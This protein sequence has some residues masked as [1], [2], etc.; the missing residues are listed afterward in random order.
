MKPKTQVEAENKE[1]EVI[2]LGKELREFIEGSAAGV[3]E[4]VEVRKLLESIKHLIRTLE[5]VGLI[6]IKRGD[7][8]R[9]RYY[10]L[11]EE[12]RLRELELQKQRANMPVKE[13]RLIKVRLDRARNAFELGLTVWIMP[14]SM[15]PQDER[16]TNFIEALIRE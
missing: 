3:R 2:R 5:R 12:L 14:S 7:R 8:S 4:R 15:K 1:Q 6:V 9:G 10:E 11:I 16:A 13:L